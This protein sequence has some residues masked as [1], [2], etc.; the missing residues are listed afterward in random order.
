M[1]L[2]IFNDMVYQSWWKASDQNLYV[3]HCVFHVCTSAVRRDPS[4]NSID[5]YRRGCINVDLYPSLH[6]GGAK[7]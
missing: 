7:H 6:A 5:F 1:E 3:R 2:T 4:K